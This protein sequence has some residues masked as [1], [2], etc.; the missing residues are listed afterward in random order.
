DNLWAVS[1]SG[2]KPDLV[3]ANAN[4]SAMHPDGKTVMF[5]HG[6]KLWIASLQ[7]GQVREFWQLPHNRVVEEKFSPDGSKIALLESGDLW[8]VPYPAG[9]PRRIGAVPRIL[10]SASWLP[11]NRHLLIA[12]NAPSFVSTLW[13]LDVAEGSRRAVYTSPVAIQRASVSPDGKRVAYATGALEWDV[14]EIS[15]PDGAVRTVLGG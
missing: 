11:D 10:D 6:G 12:T 3:L 1:A 9:T 5:E 2:G 15:L 8:I 4:A 7:D 14:L 13:L